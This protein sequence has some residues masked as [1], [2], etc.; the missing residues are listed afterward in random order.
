[1]IF[2]DETDGFGGWGFGLVL[3]DWL[4]YL[5]LTLKANATQDKHYDEAITLASS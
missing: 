3:A 1:M 2:A 4:N 5:S